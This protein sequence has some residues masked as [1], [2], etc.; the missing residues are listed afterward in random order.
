[1]VA[2][3]DQGVEAELVGLQV[4]AQA[5]GGAGDVRGA[6]G[7]V[8]VLGPGLAR[9]D[10]GLGGQV[11]LAVLLGDELAGG[12]DGLGGQAGRI[13]AHVGDEAHGAFPEVRAFVQPLGVLHG[14][15]DA[16]LQLL[17]RFLLQLG[18][19][20]GGG[21]VALLLLGFQAGHLVGGLLQLGLEVLGLGG[22]GHPA[23][24][25]LVAQLQGLATH[26]HQL[27]PE[28]GR[29]L[30]GELGPSAPSIRRG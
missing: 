24:G 27:H 19:G 5:L 10:A 8:G 25:F 7:F 22:V 17:G 13:R 28:A 14:A 30:G 12:L 16:H 11:L 29:Q 1:M 2:P 18:G 21:G 23:L 6:D 4:P 20:E 26:L 3:P 15:A 9:V